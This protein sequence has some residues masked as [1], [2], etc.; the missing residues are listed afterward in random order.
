MR[1]Y[2]AADSESIRPHEGCGS[3][4]PSPR[5][6]SVASIKIVAP[7][8]AVPST[9]SGAKVLGSTC[10]KAI[11]TSLMPI[12]FADST[13]GCSRRDSVVER[14]TRAEEGIRAI[15]IAM[16][17]F[18]SDGPSEAV[19]SNAMTSKGNDCRMSIRRWA[20]KSIQPPR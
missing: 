4:T 10:R 11:R 17:V 12:A 7:S 16:I 18:L 19:I 20:A 8:C 5:N 1:T 15:E 3:G 2:S 14:T 9:I 6:E 13:K